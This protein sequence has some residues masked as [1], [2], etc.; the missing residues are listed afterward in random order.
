MAAETFFGAFIFLCFAVIFLIG[1]F[2]S[3]SDWATGALCFFQDG[4]IYLSKSGKRLA[5]DTP[6][7]RR[8]F[9]KHLGHFVMGVSC[10]GLVFLSI[11]IF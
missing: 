11:F 4:G 10:F 1:A 3:A 8:R 7:N 2:I 6:E 5:D 9:S